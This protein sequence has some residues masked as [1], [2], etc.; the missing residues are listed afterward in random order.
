MRFRK[1]LKSYIGLIAASAFLLFLFHALVPGNDPRYLW[2]MAT[3]Y[4]GLIWVGVTLA[5]GPYNIIRGRNNP[6]SS[7]LRRDFGICSALVGLAHVVIGIQVHMGNILLYFFKAVDGEDAFDLRSDLFGVANYTGL[8]AAVILLV[9][10][11]LSNDLSLRV[12]KRSKWKT[13][14]RSTYVFFVLTVAHAVMYQVI[15]NRIPA[16]IVVL[17]LL[18]LIPI[19]IQIKGYRVVRRSK[20]S[21]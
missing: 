12:L 3:G 17:F 14:Q 9:L 21:A 13:L 8:V 15:E 4:T 18:T 11:L 16:F 20:V 2:S 6:I 1:R 7:D 10:L 19:V 5:I